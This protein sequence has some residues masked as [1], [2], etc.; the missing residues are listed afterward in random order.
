MSF[1]Q[2]GRNVRLQGLISVTTTK[3]VS[4]CHSLSWSPNE[5]KLT[6]GLL[7]FRG[8]LVAGINGDTYRNEH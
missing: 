6:Q 7:N 5:F 1:E 8:K 2:G 4:H 3:P